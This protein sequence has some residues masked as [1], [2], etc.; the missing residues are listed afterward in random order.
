MHVRRSQY[1]T[2]Q[3]NVCNKQQDNI[4]DRTVYVSL[5]PCSRSQSAD[6]SRLLRDEVRDY[7]RL[8]R[9]HCGSSH[10][11]GIRWSNRLRHLP[12]RTTPP[13][14]SLGAPRSV[15]LLLLLSLLATLRMERVRLPVRLS[16][17][18]QHPR[19]MVSCGGLFR[20]YKNRSERQLSTS[21]MNRWRTSGG[22]S[23]CQYA[24]HEHASLW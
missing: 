13:P 3:L 1:R 14:A 2:P 7:H 20:E 23:H 11:H 21:F 24:E 5:Q 6:K 18:D 8:H 17:L 15:Q 22:N 10:P 16:C 12:S 4:S 19:C 9:C